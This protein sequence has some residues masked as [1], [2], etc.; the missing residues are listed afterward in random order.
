M[1]DPATRHNQAVYDQIAPHYARRQAGR[2]ASF[3]DLMDTFTARLPARALVA[4]LGC[5][6][7][8]DGAR[9][10]QAGHRVVGVDRSA[11][12]LAIAAGPLAGQVARGDLRGLPL[13]SASLDG[14]WCCASLLHVPRDQTP[15]VL[16]ELGRVLR[17]GGHLALI[18]AL[19]EGAR[20]E[21]VP[22]APDLQR[23]YFYRQADELTAQLATAGL[24][25]LS[26]SEESGSRHWLKVLVSAGRRPGAS[27]VRR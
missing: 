22:F 6:P 8:H 10:A 21:P 17:P 18:T 7:G 14:I 20:L 3:S 23:W 2:G 19:G 26:A 16:A 25:V 27:P 11:A 13:A 12:M 15:T 5:G 24:D 1:T 4:D 9:L